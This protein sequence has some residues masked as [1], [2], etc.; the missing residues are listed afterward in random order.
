MT[1]EQRIRLN[2]QEFPEATNNG[3]LNTDEIETPEWVLQNDLMQ[4]GQVGLSSVDGLKAEEQKENLAD[5]MVT[6][7]IATVGIN[8]PD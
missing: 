8:D 5:L 3:L 7:K 1:A 6:S 2:I 4:V